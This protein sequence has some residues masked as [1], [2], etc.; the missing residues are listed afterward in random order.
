MAN[1]VLTWGL[2]SFWRKKTAKFAIHESN[3]RCLDICSGTGEM[4]FLL[5]KFAPKETHVFALDFS[6]PML[7]EALKKPATSKISF[8]IANANALPF[9]DE[10]FALITI[11]FAT[12]NIN[13]SRNIL[14]QYFLEF[15]RILKT[16]G[17]FIN[18]ETSQPPSV[19]LSKLFHLYV[20]TVV[21]PLGS[22]LSG[23]KKAYAY[24]SYT[25]PRFFP[26]K[27]LS[28]LIYRAGFRRVEFSYLTFGICAVHI[29]IK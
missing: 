15:H 9:K 17:K 26:A 11:S 12:R 25:I 1:R 20:R 18:L 4:A 19:L 5:R 21:K 10:T 28:Q 8:C 2:D 7:Q 13:S 3:G 14:P 29:A 23:S 27:E 16:G 6:F 24:L 22:L